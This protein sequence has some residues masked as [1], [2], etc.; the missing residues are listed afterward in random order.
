MSSVGCTD[1]GTWLVTNILL[2]REVI[3]VYKIVEE[4]RKKGLTIICKKT[5]CMVI[6]KRDRPKFEL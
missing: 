3:C 5:K 1:N 6:S 2:G 4:R